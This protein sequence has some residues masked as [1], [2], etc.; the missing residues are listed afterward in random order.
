MEWFT[1]F[2]ISFL[3][4]EKAKEA[5]NMLKASMKLF[6]IPNTAKWSSSIR[7]FGIIVFAEWDIIL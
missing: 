7:G 1:T 3:E 6:R 5:M 4:A 2:D